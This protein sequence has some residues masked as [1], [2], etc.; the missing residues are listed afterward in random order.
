LGPELGMTDV[1]EEDYQNDATSQSL[2]QEF[3]SINMQL[4]IIEQRIGG[5]ATFSSLDSHR[6][7]G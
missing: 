4:L 3:F 7:L 5:K 2:T 1:S 6:Q